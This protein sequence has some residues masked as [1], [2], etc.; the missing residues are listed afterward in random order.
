MTAT[1]A[2]ATNGVVVMDEVAVVVVSLTVDVVVAPV[3]GW[4]DEVPV[5]TEVGLV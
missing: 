1:V 2:A 3:E 5:E 4:V